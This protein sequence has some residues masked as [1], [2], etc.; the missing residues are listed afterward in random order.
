M[1]EQENKEVLAAAAAEKA[2]SMVPVTDLSSYMYCPRLL[3]QQKVL[4]KKERLNAA[5]ILGAIRHNFYDLANKHEEN[6]VVHLPAN[7]TMDETTEAY[8]KTYR[9][10]IK[11]AV[12]TR[13]KSLAL[14]DIQPFEILEQLQPIAAA[15]A[16]ERAANVHKFSSDNNASGESLWRQLSPKIITELRVK[17]DKMRLKGTVDRIEMHADTVI[18]IELK[19]GKMPRDGVWPAHRVQAAAYMMLL[20]ETFN[21][22]INKAIIRYLD[23]D[24]SKTVTLNPYM[25]ME[26]TELTEKVSRL[27]QAKEVPA[28]CGREGCGCRP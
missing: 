16:T 3:Y 28:P 4:G 6:I 8:S 5:M 7:V 18:P 10:L 21:A 17:S 11:A 22:P 20:Q 27:L 14:F 25:E 24:S 19:T 1:E 12:M 23:H 2:T 26:V 15:E 13:S 9:N